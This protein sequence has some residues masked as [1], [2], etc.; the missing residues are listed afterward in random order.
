[1]TQC[2]LESPNRSAHNACTHET[3]SGLFVSD[4]CIDD[5]SNSRF[6]DSADVNAGWS[7]LEVEGWKSIVRILTQRDLMHLLRIPESVGRGTPDEANDG[8]RTSHSE[9][10]DACRL[11]DCAVAQIWIRII[12]GVSGEVQS[13]RHFPRCGEPPFTCAAD[14]QA[15]MNPIARNGCDHGAERDVA[16]SKEAGLACCHANIQEEV[17]LISQEVESTGQ[18]VVVV[19][20]FDQ[21]WDDFFELHLVQA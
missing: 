9:G 6:Q 4:T 17:F 16:R 10:S 11:G 15:N 3:V 5:G 2:L 7:A 14:L 21:G 18:R 20:H 19:Y 13:L 12:F 8:G 1:M